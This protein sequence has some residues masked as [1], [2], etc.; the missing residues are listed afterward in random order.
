VKASLNKPHRLH[1]LIEVR[2]TK[3]CSS[4]SWS[5]CWLRHFCFG[6]PSLRRPL[7]WYWWTSGGRPSSSASS[8]SSF[9]CLS[10]L[11]ILPPFVTYSSRILFFLLFFRLQNS[12]PAVVRSEVWKQWNS[13][14]MQFERHLDWPSRLKEHCT[15]WEKVR[16][17]MSCSLI[18]QLA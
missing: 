13:L 16:Q 12:K 5:C 18:Y 11:F 6:L 1:G 9:S 10:S 4:R 8:S 17:N 2:S 15:E 3:P 14:R 7:G